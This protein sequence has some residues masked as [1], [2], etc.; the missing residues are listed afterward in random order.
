M[1]QTSARFARY[2]EAIGL[3]FQIADDILDIE[4][5]EKLLGKDIGSDADN[6]KSTYPSVLGM[7]RSRERARDLVS[8]AIAELEPFGAAAEPLRAIARYTIERK[9]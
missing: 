7:D 5:D 4:G 9:S 8:V 6:D 3:A 1:G 2:G